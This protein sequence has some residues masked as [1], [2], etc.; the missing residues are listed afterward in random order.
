[1]K[2][3]FEQIDRSDLVIVELSE[4]GVGIGIEAGYACAKGIPIYTIA[5]QDCTISETLAGISREVFYYKKMEDT[6]PFFR[7]ILHLPGTV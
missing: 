3:S 6:L 4:K 5:P 2:L 7:R 1:M